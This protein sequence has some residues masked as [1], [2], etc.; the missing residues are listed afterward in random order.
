MLIRSWLRLHII[1]DRQVR[2]RLA[3]CLYLSKEGWNFIYI[4]KTGFFITYQKLSSIGHPSEF[5]IKV[6]FI[7]LQVLLISYL[8]IILS[9]RMLDDIVY[10]DSITKY[11]SE[12]LV[13]LVI[14]GNIIKEDLY[15]IW[16][17]GKKTIFISSINDN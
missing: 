12:P 11:D 14:Y 9:S 10:F 4:L 16:E 8:V 2:K 3:A 15:L 5:I 17:S 1:K 13:M 6:I 7:F